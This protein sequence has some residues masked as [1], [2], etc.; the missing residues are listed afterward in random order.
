MFQLFLKNLLW[1]GA[2][3]PGAATALFAL[4]EAADKTGFKEKYAQS[5]LKLVSFLNYLIYILIEHW[6]GY[7]LLCAVVALIWTYIVGEPKSLSKS[8]FETRRQRLR[9]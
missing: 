6:L 9:R 3:L 2:S 1:T 7:A 8:K 5:H 4:L